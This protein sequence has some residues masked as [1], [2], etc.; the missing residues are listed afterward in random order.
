MAGSGKRAEREPPPGIIFRTGRRADLPAIVRMLADDPLGGQRERFVDPL[1]QAYLDAF[2]R[3]DASPANEIIVAESQGEIVGVL[4]LTTVPGLSHQG[5]TRGLIE[6]VRVEAARRGQGIGGALIGEAVARARAKGCRMVQ[7][8]THQS[9]TE[10]QR[11]Y[12]RLGFVAEHYGMK[13][14]LD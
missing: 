9:R 3:I 2:A 8:T 10:A 7:L 4:Q 13:L 11:F 12:Q 1:P 6:A 5:A 14:S